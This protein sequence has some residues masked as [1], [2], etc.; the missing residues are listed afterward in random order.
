MQV[1]VKEAAQ[2]LGVAD[3]AIFRLIRQGEIPARL[4]GEE[5]RFNRAELLEWATARGM[6]VS[7]D[8]FVEGKKGEESLPSLV[9]ALEAG[10]V[11][12]ELSGADSLSVL[13][14]VVAVLELP[15]EV[16]R[17]YLL[18]VMLARE[19]LGSTGIGEGI[20]IPHV[21]SPV[22]LQGARPCVTLCFL[23]EAI[24]FQALDGKPVDTMFAIVSPSV[25]VHL[26]LLS[27][28]GFVLR[29]EAFKA[30]LK[31]RAP[32]PELLA[33]LGEAEA[34]IGRASPGSA[35]SKPK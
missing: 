15:P 2:L 14:S 31:T 13:R 16:D 1:S 27:R 25:R 26:H 35:A 17:E 12:R 19:S 4:V 5:Y 30:A 32:T 11:V 20:A 29:H 8:L 28:L 7:P 10:G 9:E 24:D 34:T 33:V 6:K 3:E 18:E 22:I 23:A 21:R